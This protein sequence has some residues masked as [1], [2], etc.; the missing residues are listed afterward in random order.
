MAA[1]AHHQENERWRAPGIARLRL[2]STMKVT[3]PILRRQ[4]QHAGIY[5]ST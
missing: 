3:S 4:S 5:R 1:A 2:A